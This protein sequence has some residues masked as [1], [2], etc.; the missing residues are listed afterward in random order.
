MK[1][2][3]LACILT[4]AVSASLAARTQAPAPA[5]GRIIG[6]ITDRQ[7]GELGPVQVTLTT[8]GVHRSLVTDDAG[9]F[10]FEVLDSEKRYGVRAELPGFRPVA[11]E[12]VAIASGETTTVDLQLRVC[13]DVGVADYVVPPIF[14]ALMTADAVVHLRIVE[15]GP[16]RMIETDDFC[17]GV[18][19][20]RATILGVSHFSRDEWRSL[21]TIPLS[22]GSFILQAGFEYLAFLK[23]IE[24]RQQF[25]I[26]RESSWPVI[27]GRVQGFSREDELGVRDG[28]SINGALAR[29]R[30]TY[31]RHTRYRR[32]DDLTPTAPMETLRHKTGWL[33]MGALALDRDV[34]TDGQ[35]NFG[36]EERP[37]QVVAEPLSPRTLPR[38]NERIRLREGG[39]IYILD[40][41][42]RGEALR[43]R[44]PMTRPLGTHVT[45]QT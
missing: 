43:N 4:F 36:T 8:D 1:R 17:G 21:A 19:E 34:W 18:S 37:F 29:L 13:F 9:R 25:A 23:Y 30:K 24:S 10:A 7:G 3:L 5:P 11:R 33:V 2:W 38:P 22:S 44:P 26:E 41:G 12:A 16:E 15:D 32:Y 28:S 39:A 31:Q 20:A 27:A 42:S 14:D 35:R 40:F 6:Q 45:D